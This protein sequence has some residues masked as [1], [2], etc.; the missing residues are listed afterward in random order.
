MSILL[1]LIKDVLIRKPTQNE[2]RAAQIEE[3]TNDQSHQDN[4]IAYYKDILAAVPRRADAFFNLGAALESQ[5]PDMA[6]ACYR[7]AIV[8]DQEY[9]PPKISLLSHLQMRCEWSGLK[10]YIQ[11]IRKVVRTAPISNKN[12]LSPFIFLTLP[13]TTAGE[14]KRCAERYT[15]IES[16][17]PRVATLQNKLGFNFNRSPNKKIHIGYLSSD[18]RQHPI[19]LL[20]AEIFEL[21][22]RSRFHITAYSY[23]QN[24]GSIMRNRLENSFDSFVDT[25][26]DS[27]EETA[28]KIYADHIDILIDLTGYTLGTRSGILALR[29]APIQVNYLGYPGTM[30]AEFVDYLI[31]DRFTIPPEMQRCYTEKIVWLPDCFM[32]NDRTRSRLPASPRE[33]YGL[34]EAV[35]VFCCFNQPYKITEDMFNV[36]CRLL[37]NVP[38]SILWLSSAN[39]QAENNLRQ[40]AEHR[41]VNAER[42]IIASK[43][44]AIDDHLARLQCADLFLDTHPYN[45]HATCSDALWMGLPVITC[46]GK[47]FPSRVAGSLLT[48]IG[49]PE[50]ITYNLDD[51]YNLA[52]ELATD[53]NKLHALRDK[54]IA[55]RDTAP[56]F[57]SKRFTKNLE[58]A[59]IKMMREHADNIHLQ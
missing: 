59:Y 16:P 44:T 11:E 33:E 6:I 18:F 37:N 7:K 58:D 19:S 41:G 47:T 29:P 50:L 49:A 45:A 2:V 20:M 22:D 21:H 39:P 13:G 42:I 23:G 35:F 25:Q 26:S 8:L 10:S 32:P 34:P 17:R 28:K 12:H 57:D 14:Q 1:S 31:A 9:L 15:L 40:E 43:L 52:L 4:V 24:D 27:Y 56:L 3:K 55:N 54:I 53:R 46:A 30:G 38:N 48:A 5:N 36:W 51:Y